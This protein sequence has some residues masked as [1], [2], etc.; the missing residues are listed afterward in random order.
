MRVTF[1]KEFEEFGRTFRSQID[2]DSCVFYESSP[3][4]KR[5]VKEGFIQLGSPKKA[6][7][8]ESIADTKTVAVETKEL[9]TKDKKGKK[10]G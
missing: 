8:K 6:D 1:V 5:L 10:N 3:Q 2:I 7:K 9:K 4:V